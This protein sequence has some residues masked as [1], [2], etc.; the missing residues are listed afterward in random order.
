MQY[1]PA[2]M[3]NRI[4]LCVVCLIACSSYAATVESQWLSQKVGAQFVALD[5]VGI[6]IEKLRGEFSD[7]ASIAKLKTLLITLG[8][9]SERLDDLDYDAGRAA[10]QLLAA[11]KAP[12]T[13]DVAAPLLQ[14]PRQTLRQAAAQALATAGGDAAVSHIEQALQRRAAALASGDMKEQQEVAD[15]LRCLAVIGTPKARAAFERGRNQAATAAESK[16]AAERDRVRQK[17]DAIW[18][19]AARP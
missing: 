5:E 16:G 2:H 14:S 7:A 11:V 10:L 9:N 3:R 12:G 4:V 1:I 17:A 19:A 13:A 15:Y 6:N 18:S 8:T